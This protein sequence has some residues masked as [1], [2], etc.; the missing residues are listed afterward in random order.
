M[1][2]AMRRN[3]QGR[4]W[5]E[6]SVY[7]HTGRKLQLWSDYE[8]ILGHLLYSFNNVLMFLYNVSKL[9]MGSV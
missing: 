2:S 1:A 7:L 6:I 9:V 3:D 8:Q 4:L 5:A